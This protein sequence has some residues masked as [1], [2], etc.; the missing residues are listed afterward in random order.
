MASLVLV[1][2][3]AIYYCVD[4]MHDHREKKRELK[5]QLHGP[6][7][8]R[9]ISSDDD[10]ATLHEEHLP[11]YEKE[12]HQPYPAADQHPALRSD[13]RRKYRFVYRM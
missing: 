2:G 6:V 12:Y 8:E 13:K 10:N 7:L 1:I 9:S 11:A 4:K 5:S 3:V